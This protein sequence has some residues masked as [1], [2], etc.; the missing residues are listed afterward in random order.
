MEQFEAY[1]ETPVN[2]VLEIKWGNLYVGVQQ[3][4]DVLRLL[5][6]VKDVSANE[7]T[8]IKAEAIFL[9]EFFHFAAYKIW[10]NVPY[11]S[12]LISFQNGNIAVAF[13]NSFFDPAKDVILML[14]TDKTRLKLYDMDRRFT[15]CKNPCANRP[16]LRFGPGTGPSFNIR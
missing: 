15:R 12:D 9:R 16:G 5:P 7:A 3:T 2:S 1:K 4:N 6:N 11:I 13:T 8:Q 14:K 10:Q